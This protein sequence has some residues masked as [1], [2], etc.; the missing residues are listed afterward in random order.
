MS[1]FGDFL[2]RI[3]PHSNRI[4]RDTKSGINTEKKS[5]SVAP[6]APKLYDHEIRV[7]QKAAGGLGG[8][9]NPLA[10]P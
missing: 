6:E 2:V 3:F 1:I 10:G 4:R 8:A 5:T 7:A 9:V